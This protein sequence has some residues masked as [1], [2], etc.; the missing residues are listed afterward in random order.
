ML[1]NVLIFKFEVVA[2]QDGHLRVFE[3]PNLRLILDQPEAHRSIRDVD[4]R[5]VYVLETHLLYMY[6]KVHIS[7]SS[8]NQF[9]CSIFSFNWRLWSM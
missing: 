2:I 3:W 9:G 7:N 1:R 5:L 4:F 6:G 8:G